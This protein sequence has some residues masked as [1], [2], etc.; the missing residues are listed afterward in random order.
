[1]LTRIVKLTFETDKLPE[2]L[3]HFETIKWKVAKFPG[4]LGMRMHQDV[5]RPEIVFTY[6]L[7]DNE[8]ALENYRTS[9]IF[10]ELWPKIKPWF[11]ERPEAWSVRTSFDGFEG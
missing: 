9:A 11:A 7:W 3:A 10:Q 4:C 8:E 1:M 6:S 2:F 5:S